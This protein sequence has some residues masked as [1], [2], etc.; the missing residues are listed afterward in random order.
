M[1]IGYLAL[2]ILAATLCGGWALM[3]G[4]GL[5]VALGVYILGGGLAMTATICAAFYVTLAPQQDMVRA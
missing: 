1:I 4:Y 2:S 3:A 5:G